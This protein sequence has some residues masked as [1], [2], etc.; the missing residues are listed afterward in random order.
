M[1]SFKRE[2]SSLDLNMLASLCATYIQVKHPS[3]CLGA[4][5]GSSS[6]SADCI[7]RESSKGI[8][9]VQGRRMLSPHSQFFMQAVFCTLSLKKKQ[10]IICLGTVFTRFLDHHHNY[11]PPPQKLQ[12]HYFWTTLQ[13]LDHPPGPGPQ[14]P[15]HHRHHPSSSL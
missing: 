13:F 14:F 10:H 7:S 15:R 12:D 4:G 3:I 9:A 1:P 2:K 5:R 6:Q 11:G 8:G